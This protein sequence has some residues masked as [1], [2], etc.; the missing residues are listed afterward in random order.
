MQILQSCDLNFETKSRNCQNFKH[1][2]C[3]KCVDEYML[4]RFFFKKKKV[5]QSKALF[6]GQRTGP[7]DIHHTQSVYQTLT[8]ELQHEV[9]G[10]CSDK[11]WF[12]AVVLGNF[13]SSLLQK[14]YSLVLGVT[15]H[16]N[17]LALH[18]KLQQ[19]LPRLVSCCQLMLR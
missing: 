3:L 5:L 19:L 15:Q 8:T 11:V 10:T 16:Q 4:N 2:C 17:F 14:F 1:K 6:T 12:T 18:V 9:V 7:L 13:S